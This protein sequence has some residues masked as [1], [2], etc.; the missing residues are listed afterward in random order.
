MIRSAPWTAFAAVLACSGPLFGQDPLPTRLTVDPSSVVTIPLALP[1]DAGAS[2]RHDDGIE[3]RIEAGPGFRLLGG[4]TGRLELDPAELAILPVSLSVASDVTAGEHMALRA[5]F[6]WESGTDSTAVTVLV[7]ERSGLSLNLTPGQA[8]ARLGEALTVRFELTNTGNAPDSVRLFVD[9]RLGMVTDSPAA[10]LI[11]PFETVTGEFQ[12]RPEKRALEGT[13]EGILVTAEGRRSAEHDRIELPVTRGDGLFENWARIPTSVFV[14]TS[15]YPGNDTRAASP[16]YGFESAGM[17]RPG[18]RLAVSAHS[19]PADVSAFA[20]RG[21]QMGP[22]FLAELST[23]QFDA[24]AGQLYTST[25]PVLGYALQGAGGRIAL[26]TGRLAGMVHA[27]VPVDRGGNTVDGRQFGGEVEF[28]AA[29][30]S[31]GVEGVT[32]SRAA[33]PFAPA[34]DLRSALFTYRTP[35]PSRHS[36]RAEV[37]WMRLEYPDLNEATDGPAV[38]AGYTYSHG[39]NLVNLSARTRPM[40]PAD[41]D[42]PPDEFRA[43]ATIG[44]WPSQGLLGEAWIVDHPRS[45][46]LR[47][48]RIRGIS[49]GGYFL[50]GSDRYELR[51]RAQ[52]A[53]GP[54]PFSSRGV[55]GVASTSIGPGYLDARVEVGELVTGDESGPLL[56]MNAGYNLRSSR[57]WGRAGLVYYDNPRVQ[58]NLSLQVAGSYRVVGPAELYGSITTSLTRF[59]LRRSTLAEVGVQWEIASGLSILT[60]FERAEGAYAD[61]SSR[62]SVGIRQGLPLPVPVRQPRSLQGVVFEDDNGNG[63][64][65]V[66]EPLLDGVRLEM[67]SAL[68]ATR[69]GRFAFSADVPRGPL[70]IDA[71]SLGRTYLPVPIM[72]LS[73]EDPVQI[74][75][76]RPAS[77]R[78]RPYLDANDNGIQDPTELPVVDARILVR[79]TGGEM[80]VVPIG[81]DGSGSLGAVRP[82]EFTVSIDPE[83]LPRRAA[84]P[85]PLT[86]SLL[87]GAAIDLKIPVGRREVRFE[88]SE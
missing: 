53:D 50:S 1:T 54:V 8:D 63:R 38:N 68:A 13:V 5:T 56:Q 82:G 58:A 69:N 12:V 29:A 18:I 78:V 64:F 22:R 46:G 62:I 88:R 16:A 41:T 57:G 81:P 21:Y 15:L 60:A 11:G 17:V 32:E 73:G 61:A 87:G 37:G 52:S 77:L 51:L 47:A 48:D 4:A 70:L 59:D 86:L 36:L 67:G 27:A 33:G 65:D 45:A 80:W 42:L 35:G 34:R 79:R 23:A 31:F 10:V 66:G 84:A 72:P 40:T 25:S 39:R 30:G 55:E 20:F 6:D 7:T 19:A 71:A 2:A 14:G 26:R 43:Q 44:P 24:A 28:G 49:L 83:S 3:Y 75:V 74:P 85:E 9:T 76:H